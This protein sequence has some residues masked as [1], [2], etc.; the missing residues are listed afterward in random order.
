MKIVKIY[1][2]LARGDKGNIFLAAITKDAIVVL[3]RIGED[4]RIIQE[5][6]ELGSKV[7]A[8]ASE[9]MDA[10][11]ALGDI[12]LTLIVAYTLMKDPVILPSSGITAFQR[13]ILSDNSY[14]FNRSRLTSDMLI[15][16]TKLKAKIEEFIRSQVLKRH[17]EDLS[18][19]SMKATIQTTTPDGMTL[20]D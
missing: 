9:V 16:N 10:E 17:G 15:P 20:I 3:K 2:H 7:K 6:I 4:G 1:V 18:M 12:Y 13:H 14:P 5:F 8:A 11:A 19:Q